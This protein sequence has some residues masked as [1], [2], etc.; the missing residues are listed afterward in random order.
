[1]AGLEAATA[2]MGYMGR[3]GGQ[4]RYRANGGAVLACEGFVGDSNRIAIHDCHVCHPGVVFCSL[5][6]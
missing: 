2:T 4:E 5:G 3:D 6:E 1:M